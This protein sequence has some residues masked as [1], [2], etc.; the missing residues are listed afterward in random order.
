MH[1]AIG[2]SAAATSTE[3]RASAIARRGGVCGHARSPGLAMEKLA[4]GRRLPALHCQ[5]VSVI[6]GRLREPD[7]TGDGRG[8]WVPVAQTHPERW[9]STLPSRR[10]PAQPENAHDQAAPD[11]L[12]AMTAPG[13]C[14][15]R[16][17]AG[18]HRP[19]LS[20]A[21]AAEIFWR[22]STGNSMVRDVVELRRWWTGAIRPSSRSAFPR[23]CSATLLLHQHG[24]S[25]RHRRPQGT[26]RRRAGAA[27]S[28]PS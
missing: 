21:A 7:R 23:A 26:A 25:I 15:R 3:P 18:R 10:R 16:R 9:A 5:A 13:R 12:Q 27:L 14:A 28:P 8:R 19:P 6:S 4:S 1:H 24:Q 11:L 2:F 17:S 20:A 22:R